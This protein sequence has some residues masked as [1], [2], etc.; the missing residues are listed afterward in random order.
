M[1]GSFHLINNGQKNLDEYI[2]SVTSKGG[3]TEAALKIFNEQHMGEVIIQAL[4][5]AKRRSEELSLK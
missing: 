4:Q 2:A 5:S 3:T 1:L